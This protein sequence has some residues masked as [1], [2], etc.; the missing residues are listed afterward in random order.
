MNPAVASPAAAPAPAAGAAAVVAQALRLAPLIDGHNDWAWVCR[1]ERD[2]SVEGLEQGLATDTDIARLR[3][4]QVGGQFWSVYVSD[5]HAGA[6]AVQGTL[7]QIDWVYRLAARYP[8]EFVI[9][10]SAADV[11]AATADGRVASLLGAEGAH[12][13]NDSP[14]VLRMFARLGVRYLTLTHVHNTSWA[15]SGTDDPA[16]GGLT[17]RGAEYIR[18]L[19][20]LGILVDL[21][22]VSPATAHAAL[23]LTDSPV[24]FSHS[25]VSAVADHPRN[26]PDDVLLRLAANDGVIMLTFVPQFLTPEY[27]AWFDGARDTPAPAVT[28]AQVA[29]HIEHARRVAGIRH[30]GLGGDFDGTDD[31]PSGLE[32][33][34]G[35]PALLAELAGRGWS[36]EDLAALAGGNIL[37]VLRATDAAFA[38][39]GGGIPL[40]VR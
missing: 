9:A 2:Y 30:L 36:A 12:S 4:G 22:H 32:G 11:E 38:A 8:G 27:S 29:D 5:D 13:L 14:A 19:N 35:Y 34:D 6:D 37:R 15:D 24:I 23:D 16:H 17:A 20:R 39:A 10:R 33:V 7:E 21:S 3:A 18:E 40:L 25:C 28:I 1:E 31:F 26:V